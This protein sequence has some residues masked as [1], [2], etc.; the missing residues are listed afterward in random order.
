MYIQTKCVVTLLES[1]V[2]GGAV[3]RSA[4]KDFKEERQNTFEHRQEKLTSVSIGSV[5]CTGGG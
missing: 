5:G 2:W 1:L 3:G 4:D